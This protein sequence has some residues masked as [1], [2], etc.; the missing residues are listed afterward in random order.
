MATA[1]NRE[2]RLLPDRADGESSRA[3][4][5]FVRYCEMGPERNLRAVGGRAQDWSA[6]YGWVARAAEYD[7]RVLELLPAAA[8]HIASKIDRTLREAVPVPSPKGPP[9]IETAA[10]YAALARSRAAVLPPKQ[11]VEAEV[12]VHDAPG[13]AAR[14]A[15]K[16]GIS[17]PNAD[18]Q[19]SPETAL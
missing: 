9:V 10:D 11:S 16:L 13:A 14:L 18:T 5:A 15:A 1:T 7:Q 3:Y 12:T 8:I 2:H 19:E 6:A 4:N 17:L